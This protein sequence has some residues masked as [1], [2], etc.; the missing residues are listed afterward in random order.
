MSFS[1]SEVCATF[2]EQDQTGFDPLESFASSFVFSEFPSSIDL[3]PPLKFLIAFPS[4]DPISGSFLA[5]KIRKTIARMITSSWVPSPNKSLTSYRFLPLVYSA[6]PY[7]SRVKT[8]LPPPFTLS[9][10]GDPCSPSVKHARE[11]GGDPLFAQ[12]LVKIP[13][14]PLK[15]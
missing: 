10:L 3:T 4:P 15:V 12:S 14:V 6:G 9:F 13:P 1:H 11:S 5:P 7:L 8:R 2:P